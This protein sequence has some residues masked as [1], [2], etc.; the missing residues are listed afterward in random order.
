M[1]SPRPRQT[2]R[3]PI[4][5]VNAK[6]ANIDAATTPR[7]DQH[8]VEAR[9]ELGGRACHLRVDE[10]GARRVELGRERALALDDLLQARGVIGHRF[11]VER[12]RLGLDL[13]PEL[14]REAEQVV[15]GRAGAGIVDQR[16]E[17]RCRRALWP[18]TA[19]SGSARSA[20]SP[21]VMYA[22]SASCIDRIPLDSRATWPRPARSPA[23]SRRAAVRDTAQ[24]AST[25]TT[26]AMTTPAPNERESFRPIDSPRRI[27]GV[28]Y[29]TRA[30]PVSRV[31]SPSDSLVTPVLTSRAAR[32]T[33]PRTRERTR[34][35][36]HTTWRGPRHVPPR[37]WEPPRAPPSSGWA[38]RHEQRA[39][40]DVVGPRGRSPALIR[41][42]APRA[43]P[44]APLGKRG[45]S[46]PRSSPPI[47]AAPDEPQGPHAVS[48]QREGAERPREGRPSEERRP[49]LRQRSRSSTT[50]DGR[51]FHPE[52]GPPRTG[53]PRRAPGR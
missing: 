3:R 22:S 5:D 17:R 25:D 45:Q 39:E 8:A 24:P 2:M 18:P 44:D 10:V 34:S 19:L 49:D 11:A 32:T 40:D 33:A 7:E 37:D 6:P 51:A 28:V 47:D 31:A 35:P 36:L 23:P 42:S 50:R 46:A 38:T 21:L 14:A 4:H 12:A 13:R 43:R 15:D 1:M 29:M 26:A 27:G 41:W 16:L 30:R 48:G 9:E 52:R 53:S 20:A